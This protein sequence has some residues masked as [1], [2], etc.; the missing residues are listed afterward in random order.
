MD[1]ES[2]LVATLQMYQNLM[3]NVFPFWKE[4]YHHP[5]RNTMGSMS[6]VLHRKLTRQAGRHVYQESSF[7]CKYMTVSTRIGKMVSKRLKKNVI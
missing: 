5:T 7:P 6:L 3:L 4:A 2:N 1:L